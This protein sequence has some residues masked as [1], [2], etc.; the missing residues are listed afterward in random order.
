MLSIE[1]VL[2]ATGKTVTIDTH[3]A[4][5][6]GA[7][8]QAGIATTFV[9]VR[10][11]GEDTLAEGIRLIAMNGAG[12]HHREAFVSYENLRAF[13]R[14]VRRL[15]KA[16]TE[17]SRQGTFIREC[18]LTVSES[19]SVI[20]KTVAGAQVVAITVGDNRPDLGRHAVT[21]EVPG[22]ALVELLQLIRLKREARE[23]RPD[24]DDD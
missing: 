22:E 17:G 4:F 21:R 20:G 8:A 11:D 3:R 19:I 15:L 24:E 13:S 23:Q 5:M 2:S 6:P 7:L 18:R 9:T 10:I 1:E 12:D 16:L 14:S